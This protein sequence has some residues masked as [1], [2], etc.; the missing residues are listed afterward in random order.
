MTADD[1]AAEHVLRDDRG[2]HVKAWTGRDMI[3]RL[4]LGQNSQGSV[5]GTLNS[6]RWRLAGLNTL[7]DFQACLDHQFPHV[8][9]SL[10]RLIAASVVVRCVLAQPTAVKVELQ[11]M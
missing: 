4:V 11:C 8:P 7:A 5:T 10:R 6:D 2:L 3:F 1:M 9:A